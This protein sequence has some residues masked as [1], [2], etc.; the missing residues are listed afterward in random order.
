ML[1]HIFNPKNNL[2]VMVYSTLKYTTN[3][4]LWT[5]LWDLYITIYKYKWFMVYFLKFWHKRYPQFAK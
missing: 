3:F 2:F 5:F 1:N 4:G